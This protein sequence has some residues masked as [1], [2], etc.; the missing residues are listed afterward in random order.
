MLS[1][2]AVGNLCS[3]Y[4]AV[5]KKCCVQSSA[6]SKSFKI[7]SLTLGAL[8]LGTLLLGVKPV[9]ALPS[10]SSIN[11]TGAGNITLSTLQKVV[12]P[13]QSVVS[14]PTRD[15]GR[16]Y[17]ASVS[18]VKSVNTTALAKVVSP[19]N[20][21]LPV[22]AQVINAAAVAAPMAVNAVNGAVPVATFNPLAIVPTVPL[23][24]NTQQ[25]K[26]I[27]DILAAGDN[28]GRMLY[29][30]VQLAA[31]SGLGNATIQATWASA[32]ALVARS[33]AMGF[34]GG[35]GQSL[36]VK[37]GN[38]TSVNTG[39]EF[40]QILN[41]TTFWA[42]PLYQWSNVQGLKSAGIQSGY[43]M[44]LGG[45]AIGMDY[46]FDDTFRLGVAFNTGTGFSR[47]NGNYARTESDFDFWG[48]SLYAAY[49]ANNF[50]I[51]ADV[52]F[53]DNLG[54]LKQQHASISG[55]GNH[56]AESKSTAITAGI[57]L[58]YTFNFDVLDVTPH[59]GVRYMGLNNHAYNV[60]N[61]GVTIFNVKQDFQEIWYFPVGVTFSADFETDTGWIF[62]PMLD[63]GVVFAAGDLEANTRATMP[64]VAAP[65]SVNMTNVDS[66]AFN[67]G[68][69]F[70][71]SNEDVQIGLNYNL[72]ASERETGHMI[73]GS[74]RYGF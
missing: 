31:L 67:G 27:L 36:A 35:R 65:F 3:R 30:A 50:G 4:K 17:R 14:T 16:T 58:E 51:T 64:G 66:V 7:G 29:G 42:M 61:N 43:D 40:E 49:R 32:N 33:N 53:T 62:R 74:F 13:T 70:G 71:L 37:S 63:L 12:T 18:N 41:G 60:Q 56:K 15:F 21:A 26:F 72:I 9:F 1:K 11:S 22:N 5:L 34:R 59:A 69:G 48:L 8:A 23:H 19:V 55:L 28:G 57:S 39:S 52:G 45:V 54:M 2:N 24:A 6:M 25:S 44:N 46:T 10:L 68:V 73:T 38:F 47:S 20:A